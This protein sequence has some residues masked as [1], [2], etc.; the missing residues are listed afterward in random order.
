MVFADQ[1]P[2]RF[3]DQNLY[4]AVFAEILPHSQDPAGDLR[5]LG[6][7][8]AWADRSGSTLGA[9]SSL[10]GTP[11]YERFRQEM[12][13][14]KL[15]LFY[16]THPSRLVTMFYRG[17]GATAGMRPGY[18]GSYPADSGKPVY[19]Q[20]HRVPLYSWGFALFRWANWLM[21][22]EWVLLALAG[23]LVLR[24]ETLS[25]RSK[26]YGHLALW[27][28][29]A[30]PAHFWAEM[31]TEGAVETTRHLICVAFMTALGLPVLVA[32]AA[33]LFTSLKSSAAILPP[34]PQRAARQS[35]EPVG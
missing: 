12:S 24:H 6:L 21:V 5:F 34:A 29:V 27:L 3:S 28:A 19:A 22:S 31:F 32:C 35:R 1:R 20:E 7:D 2:E 8:P 30:I 25:R 9:Q 33:L 4:G 18:L 17:L 11:A 16:G 26:V 15:G 14:W 23:L 13:W 10:A